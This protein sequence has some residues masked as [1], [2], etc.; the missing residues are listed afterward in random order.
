MSLT[1]LEIKYAKP[2]MHSEGNGLYLLA[3]K[4]GAKSWI[5]RYTFDGKRREMGLG[6]LAGLSVVEARAEAGQLR[7]RIVAGFDP[8][9]ERKQAKAEIAEAK[10][11]AQ[12][13][14]KRASATFK[15]VATQYIAD[16]EGGWRNAKHRQQWENTLKTYAFPVIGEMPVCDIEVEHILEILKPIW[17]RKH[18]T[19]RRVRMRIESVLDSAKVLKLREGD[20]PAIWRGGL[21]SLLPKISASKRVRRHPAMPW[22]EIPSFMPKLKAREGVAARALEFAILTAARS[23]EVRKACWSEIDLDKRLWIIPK[24]KMKAEREH[25]VPLSK[26]AIELLKSMPMIYGC[27]YIFPGTRNQPLSDM[28][29]GAVLKRMSLGHYTVHGFRS[30]FRD[31]AA[32][33]SDHRPEAVEL[34]LAHSIA[35]KVEAAYRRGDQLEKRAALMEDWAGW[36]KA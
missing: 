16:Q 7:K 6:A 35:N 1:Q 5:F 12:L 11:K 24:E 2:G 10:R 31:W 28:S 19:A 29:L 22:E 8:I 36:C 20:N 25:R 15:Q 18:E 27:R 34:A 17:T 4:G 33:K 21:K 32:E 3:R 14:T 13:A 26:P 9:D 23:G 30:T